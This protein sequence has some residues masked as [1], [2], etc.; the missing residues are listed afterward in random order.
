MMSFQGELQASLGW[1]WS[2]GATFD[3][4]LDYVRAL[5]G[6]GSLPGAAWL[7][8]RRTLVNGQAVIYDL[9]CLMRQV[10]GDSHVTT[11]A[12]VYALLVV[13]HTVDGGSLRLGGAESDAWSEPFAAD[14]GQL[15]VPPDGTALLASRATP[16]PVD[17]ANR[18]LRLAA[19][20]GD[21][22]YSL[23]LL[24]IVPGPGSSA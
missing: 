16:W 19:A 21:V 17:Q 18:H 20:D 3:A 12:G 1:R 7:A 15:A 6:A 22:E 13:N 8:E 23:A 9:T 14:S 5:P 2:D 10:L 4:R 11:L 24:G